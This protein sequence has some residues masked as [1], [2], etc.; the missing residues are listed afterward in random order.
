MRKKFNIIFLI[1]LILGIVTGCGDKEGKSGESKPKKVVYS[2]SGEPESMDPT[3]NIYA[4][5]SLVMQN[6]FRGLFMINSKNET[7]PAM[8]ETVTENPE[9]TVYTI[10]LKDNLKWSD[11]TPL[12][13]EDFAYSWR[14]VLNPETASRVAYEMYPVKNG[15]KYNKGEVKV[16]EV[17]IKVIDPK[18]LEITLENPTPYFKQLLATPTFF[19]VKREMVEGAE[20]W[21]KSPKTYVSN[22]PF[23]IK[24]FK[25]KEKYILAKN[26]NY[27]GADNVK[28][29]ELE[30]VFIESPETEMGAYMNG[31]IQVAENLSND[32][33]KR[34]ENSSELHKNKRI[35]FFYYDFNTSKAPFN[36]PLVRKAF[37][38][39]IDRKI[40]IEK[41]MQSTN[42]PAFGIVPPGITH[43]VQTDKDYREVVGPKF[44]ES[45]EEA[46][47][48][49][50]EAGYPDG[51]GFPKVKFITT[52]SQTNKDIAQAMQN[53]WKKELNVEVE[54]VTFESKVY[55][56]EMHAGNFDIGSDG[57]GGSYP[58]P[59]TMMD[60]FETPNN[61][62]N[63]RWTNERYD[64]LLQE[65]RETNDQNLRMANFDRAEEIIMDEMPIMP[66]YFYQTQYLV[67][68]KVT[69]VYKNINGHTIFE[70]ADI[71][72]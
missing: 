21:T 29:D 72:E 32:A 8:A 67:N 3:T 56:G 1:A 42:D 62:K 34:Y 47:K 63:N 25:P 59:M 27:I 18:T 20:P 66:L 50:A 4:K 64:E 46:K 55:W 44:A 24:E 60:I 49:L 51:K 28:L 57:W 35:G 69:G 54:I 36:N 71:K 11:G 65:N 45:V 39:A 52:T 5:G 16:E 41:I 2:L 61:V 43:G 68:P 58:D 10:T 26:P 48:L 14:R 9:G 33:K 70:E 12:T 19:P 30:I 31:E 53:M 13:A 7:V 40:I 23:M 17:G 38:L 15:E 22:G 37:S 6:L